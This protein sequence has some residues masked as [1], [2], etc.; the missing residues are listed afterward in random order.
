MKQTAQRRGETAFGRVLL[1]L[2]GKSQN[3]VEPARSRAIVSWL[4]GGKTRTKR[5]RRRR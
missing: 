1:R 5:V 4:T 2:T 3:R